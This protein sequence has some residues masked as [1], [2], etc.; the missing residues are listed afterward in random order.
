MKDSTPSKKTTPKSSRRA[1]SPPKTTAK[2]TKKAPRKTAKKA[3]TKILKTSKTLHL[4]SFLTLA[5]FCGIGLF[6]AD[7]F[8][9]RHNLS[10][11]HPQDLLHKAK[12]RL[13]HYAN[14]THQQVIS[15]FI[16]VPLTTP[17]V[18]NQSIDYDEYQTLSKNITLDN[19]IR[20]RHFIS[21][22]PDSPLGI[23]LRN[24]WLLFLAQ[25]KDWNDFLI[26]YRPTN[27][28]AVECYHLA[29]LN[30]T[31]ET[32]LAL[33]GVQRLWNA[34]YKITGPCQTVFSL[35]INSQ[36]FQTS[37]IWNRL[38]EAIHQNDHD[39]IVFLTATLPT[40]ERPFVNTWIVLDKNP[41]LLP[42]ATLPPG[43]LGHKIRLDILTKWASIDVK[44][45]IKYWDFLP[46]SAVFDEFATQHFY[47]AVSL[48]LALQGDPDAEQWFARIL[49]AYSTAESRAWQVRFTLMHQNWP[50]TL[51]R[52]A[53]MP[54]TEQEDNS[55][56]YWKARALEAT[57]HIN[58]A[59]TIYSHLSNQR[60]YYGFLAAY[61]QHLTL[62]I[63]QTNYPQDSTLLAPYQQ[64]IAQIQ[65][66]YKDQQ[67][68][69]ALPLTRDL[70]NQLNPQGQYTLAHL[71]RHWGWD[72]E[73]MM[74]VNRIPYQGDLMIRFPMP[75]RTLITT[76]CNQANIP[77]AFVYALARQESNFNSDQASRAGG[78]GFLQLTLATAQ[79]F[80]PKVTQDTLYLP[81][82][83]IN[84]SILY[85]KK[86]MRQFDR[87]PLLVAAA[88]NAG[89]QKAR[90][91]Q[92]NQTAVPAD[93]WIETRPWG[94]TR[95]YLKN[96]LAYTAVYQYLL[97]NT[98]N[99]DAFMQNIPRREQ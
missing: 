15:S 33:S 18:K 61:R 92:P 96:T 99:I 56:Q 25:Q 35:W 77:P 36:D 42:K 22:N 84:I 71:F 68:S 46:K 29:A 47:L 13:M 24:N 12:I 30:D 89:P 16:P 38:R 19:T 81:E 95:N 80:D 66:L 54:E 94:E 74:I 70:L 37:D 67:F 65:T 53:A 62:N 76:L 7:Q 58:D 9:Q 52:I 59:Q 57:H 2:I 43:D 86:L 10:I 93:I 63:Q 11:L 78:I 85:L 21:T 60:Q 97:G 20:I 27:Q 6:F 90:N 50:D 75:H 26:D 69:Q 73:A 14:A 49:P 48:H 39:S 28:E 44:S 17:I 8:M 34:G 1:K 51:V 4:I 88:Y 45:A 5:I 41:A 87:Q 55:W 32:S 23:T 91:W 82:N 83:N 40:N 64:Q 31:G 79:Q 98:P 3:T 72:S